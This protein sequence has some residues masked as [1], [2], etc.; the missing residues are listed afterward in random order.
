MTFVHAALPIPPAP[1]WAI[2]EGARSAR[3]ERA[4]STGDDATSGANTSSQGSPP[5]E[6]D[7]DAGAQ[8]HRLDDAACGERR[9]VGPAARPMPLDAGT[10]P[11]VVEVQR[12]S[13]H[14]VGIVS[15]KHHRPG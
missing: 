10:V 1:W 15:S 2:S 11:V 12:C 5:D 14:I 9:I 7:L 13:W 3:S 8:T 4:A 6:V